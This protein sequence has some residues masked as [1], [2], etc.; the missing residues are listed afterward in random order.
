MN[1]NTSCPRYRWTVSHERIGRILAGSIVVIASLLGCL[2]HPLLFIVIGIGTGLNLILSGITDKCAVKSLLIRMGFPGEREIGA[3]DA[4]A[5]RQS[6]GTG[7]GI[8]TEWDCSVISTIAPARSKS[9]A[10]HGRKAD[11][12]SRRGATQVVVPACGLN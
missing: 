3:E 9:V 5:K 12:A 11:A 4:A 6:H 7:E 8:G 2:V 1:K 10:I